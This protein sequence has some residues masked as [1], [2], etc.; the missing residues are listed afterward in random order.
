[1]LRLFRPTVPVVFDAH[2]RAA[3]LGGDAL[4]RYFVPACDI[5]VQLV[6]PQ[7]QVDLPRAARVLHGEGHVVPLIAD[8]AGHEPMAALVE[9]SRPVTP[10]RRTVRASMPMTSCGEKSLPRAPSHPA[11]ASTSAQRQSCQ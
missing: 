5:L 2:Q 7:G 10:A 4:A 9:Y 11:H 8:L 3:L 6:Q 1:V